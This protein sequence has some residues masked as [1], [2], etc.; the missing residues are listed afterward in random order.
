MWLANFLTAAVNEDCLDRFARRN[1]F[2]LM[3]IESIRQFNRAVPFVPYEIHTASTECYDAPH[4]DFIVVSPKG[5][6]LSCSI[7]R[8]RKNPLSHQRPANRAR[9]ASLATDAAELRRVPKYRSARNGT[10]L[11]GRNPKSFDLFL[12]FVSERCRARAIHNAVI[13]R[14]RQRDHLCSFVF[15][16]VRN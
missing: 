3:V 8:I 2:C 9:F 10:N 5:S 16:F 11:F 6:S 13:K 7:Q 12:D 4:P 14:D 15:V 1:E